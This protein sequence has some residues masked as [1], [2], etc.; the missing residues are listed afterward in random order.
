MPKKIEELMKLIGKNLKNK[1]NWE[2][3]I[4]DRFYI[5]KDLTSILYFFNFFEFEFF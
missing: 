5:I 4:C 3:L 1:Q 2:V